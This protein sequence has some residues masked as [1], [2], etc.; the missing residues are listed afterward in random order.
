MPKV[1]GDR[2]KTSRY[3]LDIS[4]EQA[5]ARLSISPG[6]LRNIEA[7]QVPAS[8]R[9]IRRACRLY[10]TAY[11]ALVAD[12]GDGVP[13]EPPSKEQEQETNTGPGRD[14]GS[15]TGPGKGNKGPKRA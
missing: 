1:N 4:S 14:G 11:E 5:A 7:S 9:L 2:W 3:E 8:A 13:D 15:G 6:H 10:G 12:G